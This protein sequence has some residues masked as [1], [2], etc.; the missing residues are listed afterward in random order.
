MLF[1]QHLESRAFVVIH[2]R[3]LPYLVQEVPALVHAALR[4]AN[5]QSGM[6]FQSRR[7]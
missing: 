3:P 5:D 1:W 6:I 4:E 2:R 7:R